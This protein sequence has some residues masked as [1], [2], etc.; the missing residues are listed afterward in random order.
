MADTLGR[1]TRTR[2]YIASQISDGSYKPSS[3]HIGNSWVY[4]ESIRNIGRRLHRCRRQGKRRL[5][6]I[7]LSPE[8]AVGPDRTESRRDAIETRRVDASRRALWP[9]T[10]FSAQDA[11]SHFS[12]GARA[13]APRGYCN[14]RY[15]LE[16]GR[17]RRGPAEG[18]RRA[19]KDTRVRV[20]CALC[21]FSDLI[22]ASRE[23]VDADKTVS[24][25]IKLLHR[26]NEAKDATQVR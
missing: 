5:R 16:A 11:R 8:Q 26:Y 15:F 1:L 4:S 25:H 2:R 23:G 22:T 10:P 19:A 9:E 14:R 7:R 20:Q 21:A 24:K 3:E 12:K 17:T 6:Q 18:S 13:C